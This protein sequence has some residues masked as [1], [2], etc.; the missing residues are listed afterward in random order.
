MAP[1]AVFAS[2]NVPDSVWTDYAATDFAGGTE[3][4]ADPY[5]IATAEQLARFQKM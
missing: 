5:Q 3:T 4:E 2:D 1:T